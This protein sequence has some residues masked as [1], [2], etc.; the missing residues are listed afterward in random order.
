MLEPLPHLIDAEA[1]VLGVLIEKA[2]STPDIYPL[3]VNSLVA[4]CN[5]KSN[6]DPVMDFGE[7]D[8]LATLDALRRKQLVAEQSGMGSRV[9]KYRHLTGG[10][11]DLSLRQLAVVAE[12][13]LRG[14]QTAGELRTRTT[15]MHAFEALED[16]QA[17]LNELAG[18]AQ[19][20]V[21]ELPPQPGR[22][23]VR[24]AHAFQPVP[25]S[26]ATPTPARAAPSTPVSALTDEVEALKARVAELEAAFARFRQQFE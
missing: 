25:E 11:Y 13:L 17:E 7:D 23:E 12:L 2:L 5:Q 18:R 26:D 15:R 21:Y 22:R 20:I 4:G 9:T 16:V 10:Q 6:R 24:F 8:V 3:T 1:R 19:P 14:P